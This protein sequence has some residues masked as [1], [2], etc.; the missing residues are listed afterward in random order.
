[1]ANTEQTYGIFQFVEP[2]LSVPAAERPMFAAPAI[3]TAVD[4]KLVLHDFRTATDVK[5][6]VEGL[7]TQGFTFLEHKSSIDPGFMLNGASVSDIEDTYA[8]EVLD[9]MIK[10]TGAKRGIVHNIGMFK[11]AFVDTKAHVAHPTVFSV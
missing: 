7:D 9:L 8:D 10:L 6:G 1:M 5:K 2:D 11:D 3:K 4:E